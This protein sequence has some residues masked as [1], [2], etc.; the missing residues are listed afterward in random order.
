MKGGERLNQGGS[1]SIVL[2]LIYYRV[3]R[4]LLDGLQRVENSYQVC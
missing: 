3:M 1:S 4:T 2:L